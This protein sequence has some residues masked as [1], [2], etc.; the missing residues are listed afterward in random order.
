MVTYTLQYYKKQTKRIK[1]REIR[2]IHTHELV[3]MWKLYLKYTDELQKPI[4][5]A[6]RCSR[7]NGFGERS[8]QFYFSDI[9]HV[10]N[11]ITCN[12]TVCDSTYIEM[13]MTRR[14]R[15]AQCDGAT[16]QSSKV[17]DILWGYRH[18]PVTHT[19]ATHNQRHTHWHTIQKLSQIDNP[20][21]T[22]VYWPIT[23]KMTWLRV[24]MVNERHWSAKPPAI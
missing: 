10:L 12:I 14:A 20:H 1:H 18:R 11:R 17:L 22:T 21:P 2:Y 3:V 4:C 15:F 13:K 8:E 23:V 24:P 19:D 6:V 16:A 5:P 7:K 9:L